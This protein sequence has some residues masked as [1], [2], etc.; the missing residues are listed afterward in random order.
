M[1]GAAARTFI[2][3]I[4]NISKSSLASR[5]RGSGFG[6]VRGQPREAK[7]ASPLRAHFEGVKDLSRA[8]K[9]AGR[10]QNLISTVKW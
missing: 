9:S 10:S 4:S 6:H 1:V 7:K 2:S 8:G 3:N 5:R